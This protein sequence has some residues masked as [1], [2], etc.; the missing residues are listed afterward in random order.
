MQVKNAAKTIA[1]PITLR[2]QK[3]AISA[4]SVCRKSSTFYPFAPQDSTGS[5]LFLVA[6]AFLLPRVAGTLEIRNGIL[7]PC[8]LKSPQA[9]GA[10]IAHAAR[11]IL[12]LVARPSE[13]ERRAQ[14]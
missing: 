8:L 14:L 10:T 3:P 7:H 6:S 13:L 4:S 11:R 2:V 12:P 1:T 9:Q 5:Q